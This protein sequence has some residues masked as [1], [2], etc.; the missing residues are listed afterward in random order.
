MRFR[1]R[2]ATT[3]GAKKLMG[4]NVSFVGARWRSRVIRLAVL[5]VGFVGA[6]ATQAGA[7]LRIA[8]HNDPAGDPTAI[9]YRLENPTWSA[10]PFDFVLHDGE[11]KAFGQPAGS[12]TARALLPPGW[13]VIAINCIGPDRPGSV[14]I[15]VP[16]AQVTFNHQDGDEQTCSFTNG[17]VSGPA[18]GPPSSGI[19]PAPPPEELPK[20]KVPKKVALLGVRTRRSFAEVTLRLVRRSVIKLKLLRGTRVIASKRVRRRAGRRVVRIAVPTA[21]RHRLRSRGRKRVL[22]TLKISV[23]ERNGA[24]KRFRYKVI[25]P[26]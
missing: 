12:Y 21:M 26:L 25:V 10:S 7:T 19:S 17:K 2:V 14:V 13:K 11:D 8:N 18:S 9:N 20:V 23:V 5:V 15:D 4:S 16:H 1:S 6:T 24:T 22:L 3:K